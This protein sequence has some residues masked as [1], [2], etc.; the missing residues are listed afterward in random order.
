[1]SN[2]SN[3][4]LPPRQFLRDKIFLKQRGKIY[5]EQIIQ[6]HL[7]GPGPIGRT[8]NPKLVIFMTKQKSLI[9]CVLLA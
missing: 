7:W 9:V 6:F 2:S 4:P 5:I 3:N 1:M 8:C